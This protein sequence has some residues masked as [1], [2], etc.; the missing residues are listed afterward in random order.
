MR[1]VKMK[2]LKDKKLVH[3]AKTTYGVDVKAYYYQDVKEAV[4]G[5][6]EYEKLM[7]ELSDCHSNRADEI[8]KYLKRKWNVE[9]WQEISFETIFGDWKE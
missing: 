6:L 4:L 3:I 5:F 2:S 1:Q 9:N 7:D 8:C